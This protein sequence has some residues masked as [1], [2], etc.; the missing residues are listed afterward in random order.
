[1]VRARMRERMRAHA[2]SCRNLYL[3]GSL[4][5]ALALKRESQTIDVYELSVIF[6]VMQMARSVDAPSSSQSGAGIYFN[7]S[8][9]RSPEHG[10][11]D[12]QTL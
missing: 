11:S 3:Y 4:V 6:I 9:K 2:R 5:E 10:H 1:M 12:D 7:T 8:G